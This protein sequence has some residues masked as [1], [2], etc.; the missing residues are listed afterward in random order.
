MTPVLVRLVGRGDDEGGVSMPGRRAE[1]SRGAE[2]VTDAID[3]NP[4]RSP[5]PSTRTRPVGYAS[6][7]K[8]LLSATPETP[9]GD[10]DGTVDRFSVLSLA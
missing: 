7:T 5:T 2:A 8:R 4:D 1:G 6:D 9:I 3:P 10:V